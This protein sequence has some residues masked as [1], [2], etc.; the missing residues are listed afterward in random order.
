LDD[1]RYPMMDGIGY[2]M[3]DKARELMLK[4]RCKKTEVGNGKSDFRT[5]K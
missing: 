4:I 3:L 5:I 1:A 2:Q